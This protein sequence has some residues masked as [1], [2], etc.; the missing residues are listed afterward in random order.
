MG[1]NK[2]LSDV[3]SETWTRYKNQCE[4]DG[5]IALNRFCAGTGVNVQRLYEWLR[6]RK[7]SISDYQRSLPERPD[8]SR[9]GGGPLFREVKVPGIQVADESRDVGATSVVRD[10]IR[11][12]T[13][14]VWSW[15]GHSPASGDVYVFFSKDRRNED[16][17]D[18][19]IELKDEARQRER[20]QAEQIQE[21]RNA[22]E[23][24]HR[25]LSEFAD[26]LILLFSVCGE[27]DARDKFPA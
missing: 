8:S 24:Q 25:K 9:E 15:K 2:S 19:I 20:Q 12:Q 5:Y 16:L 17:Q 14:M 27:A 26:F 21:I 4:T 10:G 6:R 7:I 23:Q 18:R 1:Y 3:Y 13:Q 11:G 22:Y